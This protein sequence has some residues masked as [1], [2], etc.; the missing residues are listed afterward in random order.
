MSSG[1]ETFLRQTSLRWLGPCTWLQH[2]EY[3][4]LLSRMEAQILSLF[5]SPV[6]LGNKDESED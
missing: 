4:E 2:I 6:Q 5:Y 1:K 3:L